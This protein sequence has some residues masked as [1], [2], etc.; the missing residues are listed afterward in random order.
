M[1]GRFTVTTPI[2]ELIRA[3]GFGS[4]EMPIPP[5]FNVAPT[6]PVAAI[7]DEAPD[8][9]SL[10]RWGLIP[11]WASEPSI[12]NRMINARVETLAE[13]PAFRRALEQRRCLVL[14]DGFFEWRKE[15]KQRLPIW[16]RRADHRPFAFAG[17][18]DEWRSPD[19]TRIRSCSIVTVPAND[20]VAPIHDRM[21]A[22]LPPEHVADWLT[23]PTAEALALLSPLPA[24]EMEAIPVSPGVNRPG[25]DDPISLTPVG[26]PLPVPQGEEAGVRRRP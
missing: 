12:G 26:P 25:V 9:L 16:L 18:W 21:P 2:E 8:R 11:S 13:K 4:P 17:L 15:G 14:A 20:L 5:R 19:G 1:C 10:L 6:E 23:A 24:R 3:F 7:L 22:I